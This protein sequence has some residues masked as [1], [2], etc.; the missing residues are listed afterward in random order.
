MKLK[1]LFILAMSVITAFSMSAL[2][3]VNSKEGNPAPRGGNPALHDAKPA[4]G[5]FI[6]FNKMGGESQQVINE[7][8]AN[9]MDSLNS[10]QSK[11]FLSDVGI[12]ILTGGISGVVNVVTTQVF[13]LIENKD[14][15]K[16]EW[17]QLIRNE[18][19]YTDSTIIINGLKNFYKSPSMSGPLDPTDINFDGFNITGMNNGKKTLYL[20][21]HIDTAKL[22]N[23][24]FH[25]KFNLV[26]DTLIFYPYN[27][28]LPNLNANRIS[29]HDKAAKEC[30]RDNSF[31]FNERE[32]LN[33]GL[34]LT[35][36]SSWI[37]EAV[38]LMKNVELGTFRMNISIDPRNIVDSA[39]VYSRKKVLENRTTLRNSNI[40]EIPKLALDTN[41]IEINGD[42][43]VVPRSYMPISATEPMWGTGEF[44]IKVK[45]TEACDFIHKD[46]NP[47]SKNWKEDLAQLRKMQKNSTSWWEKV[48]TFCSEEGYSIVKTAIS[49]TVQTHTKSLTNELIGKSGSMGSMQMLGGA[50]SQ[51][52]GAQSGAASANQSASPAGQPAASPQ[53]GNSP[54][55]PQN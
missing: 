32:N 26:L 37:N 48:Q 17:E 18:C 42:C 55:P 30:E 51:V 23:L 12:A 1:K 29:T 20:S 11:G 7:Y 10:D 43:F 3:P 36:S 2:P 22:D 9:T 52:A 5:Y 13:N 25:S 54:M 28:H 16:R 15:K 33:I 46:S 31:S 41:L 35:L 19:S 44:D 50:A 21:C 53:A 34:S 14:K 47:K 45:I 27:C 38:M 39:Y 8:V 49:S 6:K 40:N 4:D 24:F